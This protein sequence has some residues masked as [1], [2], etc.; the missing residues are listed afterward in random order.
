MSLAVAY[1]VDVIP[2]R[3]A[4]QVELLLET[5]GQPTEPLHLRI[6]T[7]VPG[8]YTFLRFGR[9]ITEVRAT[10][11]DT[12]E[13]LEVMRQGWSGWIVQP[14]PPRVRVNYVASACNREWAELTGLVEHNQ[15]VLLGTYLMEVVGHDGPYIVN[16]RLPSRWAV[17]HASGAT[18]L[19]DGRHH[20]ATYATLL[21]TP[22]VAGNFDHHVRHHHGTAF[23][24]ILLDRTLGYASHL[25][26]LLDDAMGVVQECHKVF[27]P[28]P[29]KDY[30]FIASFNPQHG[31]GLEHASSC[32]VGLGP[33]VFTDGAERTRALRLMAHELGHAWNGWALRPVELLDPD[34]ERGCNPE[35]LWLTEGW[36]RYYEFV[37][38]VRAGF[39]TVEEFVSNVVNYYRTLEE[40]PAY[41]RVC[42]RDSSA[43]TF[44]NHHRYP[45]SINTSVDY[46]DLGMLMGFDLDA[47]MRLDGDEHGLDG[48][49]RELLTRHAQGGYSYPQVQS[50][51]LQRG[52]WLVRMLSQ[53]VEQMAALGTPATLERLGFRLESEQVPRLGLFFR[54]TRPLLVADVMDHGPAACA[55]IIPGD[56][57]IRVGGHPFTLAALQWMA[58][59]HDVVQLEV[60][61]GHHVLRWNIRPEKRQRIGR[62]T[63]TGTER[64]A[65]F[66]QSWLGGDFTPALGTRMPLHS[67]ENFHGV[68]IIC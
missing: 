26:A 51:C 34:F 25:P 27:G 35:T 52:E 68:P 29:F 30:T 62:L 56:E 22:V 37:L 23:H 2:Q 6:P 7:W 44:L 14:V 9:D 58:A 1:E 67:H 5:G 24:F 33:E 48:L 40:L 36:T 59:H 16:W 4:W 66:I 61:R 10:D 32:T 8:A 20:Y 63:W 55:G 39:M 31:W 60:R 54:D 42:A 18:A 12:G 43:A 38:A 45:G 64:Q 11:A 21:D 65:E 46:Y 50:C 3:H 47:A 53:R 15:A 13:P 28:F 41:H 49:I 57:I 17:H 19:A